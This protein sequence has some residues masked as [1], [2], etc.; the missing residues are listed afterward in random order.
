MAEDP[1]IRKAID[2]AHEIRN[3]QAIT[4]TEFAT[5]LQG[6]QAVHAF[7]ANTIPGSNI[8]EIVFK[9]DSEMSDLTHEYIEKVSSSD[10]VKHE[11][12]AK[13][14][15]DIVESTAT[16]EALQPTQNQFK[17]RRQTE[18]QAAVGRFT[19]DATISGT[20]IQARLE[21]GDLL[22]VITLLQS[23]RDC[24]KEDSQPHRLAT[25]VLALIDSER[26]LGREMDNIFR[27]SLSQ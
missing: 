7:I 21:K 27:A 16:T 13:E 2:L 12:L 20:T 6:R 8:S 19:P 10:T 1:N 26:D 4:P 17:L 25:Q 3:N 11:I 9:I 14:V 24:T 22:A 23:L 15:G 18:Y 5:F